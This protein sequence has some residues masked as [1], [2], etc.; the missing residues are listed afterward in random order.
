LIRAERKIT[1]YLAA[2]TDRPSTIVVK[3]KHMFDITEIEDVIAERRLYLEGQPD[4]DIR[5]R[6]GRPQ[7]AP[8]PT[9]DGFVL[10]PFQILGIGTEKVRCAGGVDAVQALQLVMEMIGAELHLKLNRQYSGKLRWEAGKQ[11]DLGFP[12]HPSGTPCRTQHRNES[13]VI[14]SL[15]R[16]TPSATSE[17]LRGLLDSSSIPPSSSL[18]A[19]P[20]NQ[21]PFPPPALPGFNSTAGLSVTPY[22]PAWLSRVAS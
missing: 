11:T 14:P 9:A 21:G 18:L 4:T 19:F 16:A 3:S 1:V 10:C 22:G 6:V 17:H 12:E 20:F 5:I 2:L 13:W 15:S 8:S 7:K